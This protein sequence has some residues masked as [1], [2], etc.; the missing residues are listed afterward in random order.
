MRKFADVTV[1]LDRSGSMS[2]IRDAAIEQV[3]AFMARE[4]KT[5]GEGCWTLVTFDDPDSAKGR[6]EPFPNVVF[7][8]IPGKNPPRLTRESYQPWGMTAL[9]DVVCL[10]INATGARL[11]AMPEH[12]RPDRVVMVIVTDGHD[13]ESKEFKDFTSGDQFSKMNAMIKHQ[14]EKY[15]WAFM[16]L[17]ANQDSFANAKKYGIGAGNSSN[18]A[19]SAKGIG[20]AMLISTRGL[21]TSK[22]DGLNENLLTSAAPDA[23]ANPVGANAT[24]VDVNV[25]PPVATISSSK[26]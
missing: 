13:N 21:R 11:A 18:F 24:S 10:T 2:G 9:I 23:D 6:C 14:K 4:C 3:N 26:L 7:A 5:P 12:L 20:D 15:N 22:A 19:Y 1:I 17:G 8:Q 16:F 25:A